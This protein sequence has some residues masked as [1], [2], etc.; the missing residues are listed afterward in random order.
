MA[1]S[2]CPSCNS[3]DFEIQ[4]KVIQNGKDKCEFTFVQCAKCGA[5]LGVLQTGV[6]TTSI[7]NTTNYILETIDKTKFELNKAIHEKKI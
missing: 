6:I 3:K 5:V 2:K 7:I 4:K 1:E